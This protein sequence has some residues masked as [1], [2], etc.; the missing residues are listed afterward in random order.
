MTSLAPT[1]PLSESLLDDASSWVAR[2][3]SDQVTES[4]LQIFAL[5][6]AENNDHKLAYDEVAELWLDYGAVKHLPLNIEMAQRNSEDDVDAVTASDT[7]IQTT[8]KVIS[9]FGDT[10]RILRHWPSSI[11]VAASIFLA[12]AVIPNLF[13]QAEPVR[14]ITAIGESKSVDLA[15]GSVI[16]L[17][18]NTRLDVLLSERQRRITLEHGEAFFEV[19]KDP[20]R[21][22]V[23]NNCSSEVRAIGTAFNVRCSLGSSSV[24]VAEGIVKVT[25]NI[26]HRSRETSQVLTMGEEIVLSDSTGLASPNKLNIDRIAAWRRG[27]LIFNNTLLSDVLNEINR[28]SNRPVRLGS[29]ELQNLR[30][31]GRFGIEDRALLLKA[32]KRSLSLSSETSEDGTVRL[33]PLNTG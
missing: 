13:S 9:L 11:A 16:I 31:T 23:V 7:Q 28:Y 14:Y 19:A 15:D 17:N 30:V 1:L 29:P 3:S 10:A 2:L 25:D 18:T 26:P 32:L 20:N 22:F 24:A 21:P 6:L 33:V 8:H 27:E 5:W 4:D 12:I